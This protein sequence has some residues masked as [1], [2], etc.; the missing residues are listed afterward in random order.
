VLSSPPP[1]IGN[2]FSRRLPTNRA[3]GRHRKAETPL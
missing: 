1:I 2:E 3:R